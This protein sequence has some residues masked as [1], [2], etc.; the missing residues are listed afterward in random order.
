MTS[1]KCTSKM[2]RLMFIL[3][4]LWSSN[5]CTWST[6]SFPRISQFRGLIRVCPCWKT[7]LAMHS[8]VRGGALT[9]VSS[10]VSR[11]P[12]FSPCARLRQPANPAEIKITPKNVQ[13]SRQLRPRLKREKSR[14]RAGAVPTPSSSLRWTV[15]SD[16][17]SDLCRKYS[18]S[19]GLDARP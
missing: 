14:S 19:T 16:L 11:L 5:Y 6:V 8:V 4:L 3:Q 10:L 15:S 1:A 13:L 18:F 7:P 17:Y 12:S 2:S 9:F